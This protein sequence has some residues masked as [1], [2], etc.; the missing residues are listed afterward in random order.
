M[1][2]YFPG[3]PRATLHCEIH[4]TIPSL[5]PVQKLPGIRLGPF[6][7]WTLFFSDNTRV[8]C[9]C[10]L[11]Y[12]LYSLQGR[13]TQTGDVSTNQHRNWRKVRCHSTYVGFQ[14]WNYTK[15]WP[16][17]QQHMAVTH[18]HLVAKTKGTRKKIEKSS[19]TTTVGRKQKRVLE[20]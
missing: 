9:L 16:H 10:R 19:A 8:H 17:Q 15:D 5:S 20:C 18:W 3:T 4:L 2:H 7:K 11:R 14:N 6:S 1:H 12:A 13:H